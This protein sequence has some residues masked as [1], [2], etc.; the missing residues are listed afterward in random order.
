MFAMVVAIVLTP[1][2]PLVAIVGT[3][4]F[5]TASVVVGLGGERLL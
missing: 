5:W 2:A 3:V 1:L 4:Y